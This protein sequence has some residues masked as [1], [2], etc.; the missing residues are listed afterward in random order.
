MREA[1]RTHMTEGDEPLDLHGSVVSDE[2]GN[3]FKAFI[4][5]DAV[6]NPKSEQEIKNAALIKRDPEDTV[7]VHLENKRIGKREVDILGK[8]GKT[9]QGTAYFYDVIDPHHP[10]IRVG[11]SIEANTAQLYSTTPEGTPEQF[12]YSRE[13]S[14]ADALAFLEDMPRKPGDLRHRVGNSEVIDALFEN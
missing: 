8:D 5:K 6:P 4:I 2:I 11:V 12:N 9:T 10:G 7:M 14:E 13:L 1:M 3:A